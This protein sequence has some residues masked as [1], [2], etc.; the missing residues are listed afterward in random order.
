MI[1]AL[2]LAA[3]PT[4]LAALPLPVIAPV[5]IAQDDAG[6]ESGS[7]AADAEKPKRATAWP[8]VPKDKKKELKTQLARL[9]KASTEGMAEGG[10][11]EL[12]KMGALAAPDLLKA[13]G[14]EKSEDGRGRIADALD[15]ITGWEHTR[16]LA[17]EFGNRSAH[18]RLL[19]LRRASAFPDKGI[20]KDA[21]AAFD[22]AE[23]R[24]DTKKEVKHELYYSALAVV[25]A[26]DLKGIAVLSKRAENLWG[27][28]GAEIRLAV[29]AVRGEA[30]TSILA[31]QLKDGDRKAKVSALRL[32]AG[33]GSAKAGKTAVKGY[34]GNTDNSIRVAAIN[35]MR[36][37]VDGDLPIDKLSVFEAVELANEWKNR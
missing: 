5:Q 21:L 36:G 32:L 24:L 28:S 14:K 17:K 29:E 3:L 7:E 19:V 30:A 6:E 12:I 15:E 13:L 35:A 26:G 18:V 8:E 22:A 16:L 1:T 11:A 4:S 34:L 37:I 25:S 2:F 9:R 10:R 27:K 31:E 33:C 20:A 23:K